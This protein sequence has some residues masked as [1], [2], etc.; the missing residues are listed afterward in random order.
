MWYFPWLPIFYEIHHVIY[1]TGSKTYKLLSSKPKE[2]TPENVDLLFFENT[3]NADGLT[4]K[5]NNS[6]FGDRHQKH[7]N[8][9]SAN[10]QNDI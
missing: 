2:K 9:G 8:S 10:H 4:Y 7:G 1:L 6:T 5:C 3:N